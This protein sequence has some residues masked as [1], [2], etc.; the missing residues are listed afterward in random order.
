MPDRISLARA[1]LAAHP[2]LP[3]RTGAMM[4]KAFQDPIGHKRDFC[5]IKE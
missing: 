1:S 5:A 3:H 2:K 4:D